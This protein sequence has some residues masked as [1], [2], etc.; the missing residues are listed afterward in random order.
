MKNNVISLSQ[1]PTNRMVGSRTLCSLE[2]STEIGAELKIEVSTIQ[3]VDVEPEP[4]VSLRV[5][6]RLVS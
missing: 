4:Q 6:Q 5:L 1:L 2:N 3:M